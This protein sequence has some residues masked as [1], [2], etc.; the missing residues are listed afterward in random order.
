MTPIHATCVAI[1]G[2]GVLLIGPSGTGKSDLA[3]RLIDRG[4]V[5]VSDDYV[6]LAVHNGELR[7][8]PPDTI[9]GKLEVRGLG[10][11]PLPFVRDVTVRLAVD[12]DAP[13]ARFPLEPMA[14]AYLGVQLA[15]IRLQAHEASTPIKVELAVSQR[16]KSI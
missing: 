10:I 15:L 7:A 8:S 13:P 4:A 11:M 12:L 2:C 5:L 16:M 9:A 3:L 1:E 6:T 14:I